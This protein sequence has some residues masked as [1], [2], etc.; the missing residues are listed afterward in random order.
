[1]TSSSFVVVLGWVVVVGC[2]VEGV[3]RCG[4]TLMLCRARNACPIGRNERTDGIPRRRLAP[5]S[6]CR[7]RD[8][9]R[10]L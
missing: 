10:K 4:T 2:R 3:T 6:F 7:T 5:I 9:F 1:M 8:R